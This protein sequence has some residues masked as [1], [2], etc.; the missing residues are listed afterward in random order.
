MDL[1]LRL[2]TR[3]QSGAAGQHVV[4]SSSGIRLEAQFSLDAIIAIIDDEERN[5]T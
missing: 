1:N 4:C 2:S 3:E 5:V